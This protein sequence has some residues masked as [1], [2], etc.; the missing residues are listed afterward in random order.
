MA[1]TEK[2]ATSIQTEPTVAA[3][4]AAFNQGD[5]DTVVSLFAETGRLKAPFEEMIV[6]PEA[7]RAYL[8]QEAAGMEAKLTELVTLP[9]ESGQRQVIVQGSVKAIVFNVK[10]AWTF[11]LNAANQ[12]EEVQVKLLASLEDLVH[13]HAKAS[14]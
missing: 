9:L 13:L 14:A 1:L 3:Y 11:C 2:V 6:G 10:V 12:L 4:F 8:E 5:F 7:I